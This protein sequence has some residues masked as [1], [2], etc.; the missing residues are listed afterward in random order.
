MLRFIEDFL[1][2]YYSFENLCQIV[3][4]LSAQ[5]MYEDSLCRITKNQLAGRDLSN[6]GLSTPGLIDTL[7]ADVIAHEQPKMRMIIKEVG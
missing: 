2:L 3:K 6:V 4:S 5:K 7:F 1:K